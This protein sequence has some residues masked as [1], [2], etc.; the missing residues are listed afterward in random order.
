MISSIK[1]GTDAEKATRLRGEGDTIWFGLHPEGALVPVHHL[2]VN[3]GTRT[4][5][6]VSVW[7]LVGDWPS[8]C[9]VKWSVADAAHCQSV[10]TA[11]PWSNVVNLDSA[12]AV[13]T[14]VAGNA[15]ADVPSLLPLPHSLALAWLD[16][17]GRRP[18]QLL[19]PLRTA[20][21]SHDNAKADTDPA[22]RDDLHVRLDVD[23]DGWRILSEDVLFYRQ[24]CPGL[25]GPLREAVVPS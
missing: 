15:D 4:Q 14:A 11:A 18:W 23:G 7:V 12:E 16:E 6:D 3:G 5:P 13:A 22:M 1:D 24:G 20:A 9:P 21:S 8:A 19:R 17:P 2:Y 25:F 10:T